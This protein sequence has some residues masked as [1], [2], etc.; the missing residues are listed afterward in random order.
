[1][2]IGLVL[3]TIPSYSETFFRSKVAGLI[4]GGHE[5]VLFVH[6]SSARRFLNAK[7]VRQWPVYGNRISRVIA[8]VMGI[9]VLLLVRPGRCCRFLS[10]E[11]SCGHST[12]RILENLYIN[13][14]ILFRTVDWLH[15]GFATMGIRRENVGKAMLCP[16]SASM[17]GYDIGIYPLKHPGCYNLLWKRTDKVHAISNDIIEKA[18]GAGMPKDLPVVKIA[19]AIDAGRFDV[20]DTLHRSNSLRILTIA[21]LNWKKGLEYTLEALA[22]LWSAYHVDFKYTIV[23][24]GIEYERL[25]FGAHQLG[26]SSK[27]TFLGKVPPE[28]IPLV[29][30]DHDIYVQ[31]SIQEGFSN[32]VLEAQ[33]AGLLCVVSDAEGLSENVLH[34]QTGFVV[35]RRN[36]AALARKLFEIALLSDGEIDRL[37]RAAVSRV[38]SEFTLDRQQQEFL[39]FFEEVNPLS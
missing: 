37:T 1:M 34:G 12:R 38:R 14:H 2:R 32:S 27:V 9:C 10:V 8:T 29:M 30:K 17:R 36:P 16:V 23:G 15:F 20:R 28:D 21:R 31:Y 26:I 24:S 35:P 6:R 7:V 25:A 33:A 39:R 18:Y 5:V 13:A 11:A 19:P 3:P 22:Q 4:Q